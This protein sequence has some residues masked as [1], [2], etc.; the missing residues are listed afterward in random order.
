MQEKAP[1]ME[2]GETSTLHLRSATQELKD[3]GH[4]HALPE[5]LRRIVRSIAADGRGEGGGGG[6]L[7]VRERG[8]RETLR[9]T[10]Q[11]EWGS[12][13]EDRRTASRSAAKLLLEH[14]LAELPRGSRGVPTSWPRP[15]WANSSR[16]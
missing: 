3:D 12:L 14:L 2:K 9:V 1:D 7:S 8:D 10:L 16:R 5:L 6:S 11:R 4:D 15:P 13:S